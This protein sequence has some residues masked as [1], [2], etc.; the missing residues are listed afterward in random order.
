MASILTNIGEEWIAENNVDGASIDVGVYNDSTDS[1]SDTDDLPL[2]TEPDSGTT[3]YARQTDTVSSFQDA[4]NDFGFQN[5]SQLTF[6]FSDVTSSSTKDSYFV[7][8]N[9]TAD[10]TSGDTQANDHLV[11][12]GSLSQNRDIGSID[13][14]N[15][16]AGGVAVTLD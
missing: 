11:A 13:T 12:T 2:S 10:T 8:V 6:D 3:N 5:D 1:V 14:L 7:V 15:I 4:N 16:S 9:F